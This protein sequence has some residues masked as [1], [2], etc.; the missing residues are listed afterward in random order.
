M[1]HN[2]NL[3]SEITIRHFLSLLTLE[4]D[5]IR[6]Y[7]ETGMVLEV[8]DLGVHDGKE[9]LESCDVLNLV[10]RDV[11]SPRDDRIFLKGNSK[12]MMMAF[13]LKKNRRVAKLNKRK[14][15]L[16]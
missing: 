16:V 1:V 8:F 2:L 11:C 15:N 6:V 3:I 4:S 12:N 13:N 7:T 9:H 5:L 14:V 10:E